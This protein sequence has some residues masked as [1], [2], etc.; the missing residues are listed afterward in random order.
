MSGPTLVSLYHVYSV[1]S[2][3]ACPYSSGSNEEYGVQVFQ[4]DTYYR[5]F[6]GAIPRRNDTFY[7]VSFRNV[8]LLSPPPPYTILVTRTTVTPLYSP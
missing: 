2:L 1:I 7:V 6:L 5:S 8:S 3:C 4:P